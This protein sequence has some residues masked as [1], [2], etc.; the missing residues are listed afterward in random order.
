MTK[1]ELKEE[2]LNVLGENKANKKLSEAIAAILED[3]IANKAKIEHPNTEIDGVLN[4]WCNKFMEYLPY[5]EFRAEK[6]SS[7]GYYRMSKKAEAIRKSITK[8]IN[9][10]TISLREALITKDFEKASEVSDKIMDLE[11]KRGAS[12]KGIEA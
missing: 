1:V 12:Y 2:V 11:A 4:V 7:T 6:R 5:T 9:S 8:E 3:Y 10:L